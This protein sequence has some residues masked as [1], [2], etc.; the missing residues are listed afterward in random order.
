MSYHYQWYW[1]YHQLDW[2]WSQ[3][4]LEPLLGSETKE[5]V[6]LFLLTHRDGYAREMATALGYD[7]FR[8][9]NQLR[10]LEYGGVLY[11]RLRGKT[12]LFGIDPRYPFRRELE[13]LLR[14][15]LEALPE[16]ERKK[17]YTP[18]LRPRRPGRL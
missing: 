17:L 1:S 7:L 6:L 13:A 15:A 11:S 16:E 9:Q 4:M 8:V 12:R 3:E 14:R 2:F 5:R 18:R 10:R